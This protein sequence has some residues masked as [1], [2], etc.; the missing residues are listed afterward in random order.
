MATPIDVVEKELGPVIEIDVNTAMWKMPAT[1]REGFE[2]LSD[3]TEQAGVDCTL[4]PYARFLEIDWSAEAKRGFLSTLIQVFSKPSH[5]R[6][7]MP[8]SAP[9]PHVDDIRSEILA[10]RRYVRAVHVGPYQEVGDTY[11]R[12]AVWAQDNNLALAPES[13]ELYLNDP[14]ITEKD[15]LQTELLI[16]LT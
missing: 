3:V 15:Q 16:P 2:V 1:M 7:G 8:I 11:K 9:I 14:R 5:F 4:A 12:M 6:M 10:N 13:I